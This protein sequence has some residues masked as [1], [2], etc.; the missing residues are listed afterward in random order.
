VKAILEES[1]LDKG[2]PRWDE[3]ILTW[4]EL[5]HLPRSWV[6]VLKHW[7]G[8]Y[9]IVDAVDGKG[10]VGSAYG[11]E[12]LHHRWKNYADSGDGGNS[13]LRNRAPDEFVFSILELV[14]PTM[15]KEDVIQLESSWKARLHTREFGLN[16]N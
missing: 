5:A 12:N 4:E 1:A 6:H 10:Y 16:A 15:K 13:R 8:V 3:L 9:F 7:R 14:S 2:M 11:D